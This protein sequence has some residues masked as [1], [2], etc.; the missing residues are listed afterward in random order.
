MVSA[1]ENLYNFNFF[2][3]GVECGEVSI[4]PSLNGTAPRVAIISREVGGRSAFSCP[5]GHGLK[6]PSESICLPSGEWSGPFPTCLGS[7]LSLFIIMAGFHPINI[8]N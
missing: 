8:C 4:P 3:S 7:Y 5:P 2:F 6:G 1:F